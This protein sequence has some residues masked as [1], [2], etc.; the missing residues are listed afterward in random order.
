M[1]HTYQ[2]YCRILRGEYSDEFWRVL[3]SVHL[4]R[5]A[6]I[7]RVLHTCRSTFVPH[8]GMKKRFAPS[9][10]ELRSRTLSKAGDFTSF[11]MHST[12][13]DLREF[14]L[15]GIKD[16][17]FRFLNP[18]WG[19]V[20]AASDMLDAGHS[21]VFE[22]KAMFHESTQE[23]IYGAGVAF[24][25]KL[26]WASSRTPAGGKPALFGVSFDGADPGI[27]DRSIYPVCVSV[28]NFDGAEPL[29]CFLVGY[30]PKLDV[31]KIFKKKNTKR[32]LR[33]RGHLFQE[34]IAAVI[35]E[36]ENVAMDGFTA[37]LGGEKLRL[38]PFLAAI[39]VDSKERKTY[40]GLKSDRTCP[41]CR[42]RKGW[43]SLRRGT[44]HGK[45]HIQR[46]WNLAIDTP[47]T[48]R[49]DAF[50][51]TQKRARE[52]L[53][54]HGFS[55]TQ[56][57]TLLDHADHILLRDPLQQR[58]LLFANLIFVDLL[59]WQSNVC[60]YGFDALVGVMSPWMKIECDENTRQLPMFRYADGTTVRRFKMVS[61]NTYLT[62]ARRLTLTFVWIHALGTGALMLPPPCR[63][64]ALAALSALQRII[65]A[66][67]GR[68]SYSEAEWTYLLV[69]S[70][71]EYFSA[72][73]FLLAYQERRYDGTPFTPM[74]RYACDCSHM[75]A[76]I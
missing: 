17:Q 71:L 73:E 56:R 29:A 74:G 32:F 8:K 30:I 15:P 11:L 10:R 75:I 21:I 3:S 35:D 70:A 42:F 68:R 23:R 26:M 27:S 63:I 76:H 14:S 54:R 13:I 31:P 5:H 65:L 60:D 28:L 50:A 67:H 41:I 58:E 36:I 39:R 33:A 22:P 64:P 16:V 37:L 1:Q 6:V 24:G 9:V 57:C 45:N 4:E 34:C 43:S 69:D 12:Q 19:W 2:E 59:H 49:R 46:L 48:R 25:D 72:L 55:K 66:C 52:Q 53:Q 47:R 44:C 62:T 38:H 20:S 61:E 7:D 51:T 40:F 18:L